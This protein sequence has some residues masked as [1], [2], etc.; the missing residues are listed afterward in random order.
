MTIVGQLPPKARWQDAPLALQEFSQSNKQK[1]RFQLALNKIFC[2][3]SPPLTHRQSKH[4]Q[5]AKS[6]KAMFS[7]FLSS[8]FYTKF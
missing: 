5:R 7:A 1:M 4:P 8:V 3:T 6:N 2:P